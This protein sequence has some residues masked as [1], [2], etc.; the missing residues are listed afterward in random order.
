MRPQ[1]AQIKLVIFIS[2]WSVDES[3]TEALLCFGTGFVS[4]HLY[5]QDAGGVP[6]RIVGWIPVEIITEGFGI[7]SVRR[8]DNLIRE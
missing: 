7:K 6:L 1:K 8:D 4:F 3:A 2:T 5:A